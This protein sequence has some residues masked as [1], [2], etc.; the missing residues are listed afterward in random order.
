MPSDLA[1]EQKWEAPPAGTVELWCWELVTSDRLT[2]KLTP[3]QVPNLRVE[4][5]W[6]V[7][8]PVRRIDAPGRPA[9]LEIT[10]RSPRTP[11]AGALA[12]QEAR[13]NLVHT[14]LHHEL[15][16]AELFAWAVLA[17]PDT[18]R[19]FR[20]G[21]VRLAHEELEHLSFYECHLRTLGATFGDYPVRDWFWKR[22][23][24]CADPVA[25]VA[26]LGIGLEGAN[27]DHS[28]R[29]AALFRAAGDEAGAR[30]L[31]R[32]E[33]EEVG[34]VAFARRWFAHFAGTFDYGRWAAALPAPL[35][36]AILQGRPLNR[37]ARLAAGLD[38]DFLERLA[39]EPPT[40]VGK[41][42]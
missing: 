14:F 4:A 18:P 24:T 34:H 1:R 33:R 15:Q 26:L 20:R 5:S 9:E 8:P 40:H 13:A 29:F 17:F 11:G 6:E 19:A 41:R 23:P 12:R 42:P 2:D 28:V 7:A 21:L 32:V 36:P 22:V 31:E 30:I 10:R 37:A 39:G 3:P 35:T 27:L 16:A 25:F 38:S